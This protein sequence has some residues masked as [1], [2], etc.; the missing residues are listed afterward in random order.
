MPRRHHNQLARRDPFA[1]GLDLFNV[2]PFFSHASL[3]I[4]PHTDISESATEIKVTANVPGMKKE[5]VKI[6]L[7][8]EH[9]TLTISG[10]FQQENKEDTE[11]YHRVERHSGKFQ[12]SVAL[13]AEADLEKIKASLNDGVLRV[14]IPK[15]GTQEKE[16]KSIQIE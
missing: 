1:H 10:E 15:K 7:D 12:R 16:K 14:S 3:D 2:D 5:D 9:R 6:D 4:L 8:E 13:P 11:V